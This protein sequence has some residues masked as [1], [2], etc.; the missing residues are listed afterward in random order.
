MRSNKD[1]IM[2][3]SINK[4]EDFFPM[5]LELALNNTNCTFFPIMNNQDLEEISNFLDDKWK[6]ALFK[7]INNKEKEL[8]L[9]IRT[10]CIKPKYIEHIKDGVFNIASDDG[11]FTTDNFIPYV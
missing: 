5:L 10:K 2:Y 1:E 8:Y 3:I 11:M 7:E 6:T 9:Y 4:K